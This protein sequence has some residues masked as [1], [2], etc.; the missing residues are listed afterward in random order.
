MYERRKTERRQWEHV[1]V[2]PLSDSEGRLVTHNRRR[3]GERRLTEAGDLT[4]DLAGEIRELRLRFQGRD[5]IMRGTELVIGRQKDCDLI[6]AAPVVSRHHARIERRAD[7]YVLVDSSR[8]GTFVRFHGEE[9]AYRVKETELSLKG[10]GVIALG[11]D[12]NGYLHRDMVHF[13]L[14]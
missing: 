6:V 3:R 14:G 9:E 4:S 8:N 11:R 13:D 12:V 1:P 10:P 5:L 7:E 2:Y